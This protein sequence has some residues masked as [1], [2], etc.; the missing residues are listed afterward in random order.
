MDGYPIYGHIK[1]DGTPV[2]ISDLDSYGG[3]TVVTTEYPTGTYAYLTPVDTLPDGTVKTVDSYP[4]RAF[5]AA[6]CEK[7]LFSV[8]I[9]E[10]ELVV[11]H[12]KLSGLYGRR[13][14]AYRKSPELTSYP[15]QFPGVRVAGGK[16]P[17]ALVR[18]AGG[19]QPLESI[20]V[21][22]K[23]H[24]QCETAIHEFRYEFRGTEGYSR[25][26]ERGGE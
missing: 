26:K 11:E 24:H 14:E 22:G 1:P 23:Q 17:L 6:S 9:N 8:N 7:K 25:S 12:P 18:V 13:P 3:T 16:Q 2:A 4:V 10:P 5:R 20:G 21:A 15:E 19:K